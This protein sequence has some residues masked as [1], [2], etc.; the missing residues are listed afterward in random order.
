MSAVIKHDPEDISK[1]AKQLFYE[2]NQSLGFDYLTGTT[3][4]WL[5]IIRERME[6]DGYT[7]APN[8]DDPDQLCITVMLANPL[9]EGSSIPHELEGEKGTY[10]VF[11]WVGGR[12]VFA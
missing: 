1:S 7:P 8:P 4:T 10:K 2:L 3:V 12:T 11:S 9:P 5:S 6:T